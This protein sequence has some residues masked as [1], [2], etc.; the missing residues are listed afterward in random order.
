MA[1]LRKN[2]M[3]YTNENR[4]IIQF[5]DK[6][7]QLIRFDGLRY[8]SITPTDID[9]FAEIHNKATIFIELKYCEFPNR[10]YLPYGQRL[11]LTRTV[12][13]IER[14][15]KLAR[16]FVCSHNIPAPNDV[17]L[18]DANVR[19]IYFKNTWFKGNGKFEDV[20][21]EFCKFVDRSVKKL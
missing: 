8:G 3:I 5:P 20:Y 2:Y 17:F 12:D 10:I 11:A 21:M 9:G 13:D 19:F 16:L 1:G 14:S 6:A 7:K 15:G 18:K 4:G